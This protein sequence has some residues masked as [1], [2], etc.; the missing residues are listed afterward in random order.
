MDPQKLLR[1]Q[2][3][4]ADCE[5]M[6]PLGS[7]APPI[8][9]TSTF[10]FSTIKEATAAFESFGKDQ[11]IYTRIGNPTF[12][13][14]EKKLSAW[15]H[16]ESTCLFA[17]GMAAV[18]VTLFTFL[19]PGDHLICNKVVYGCTN[20]LFS[21]ILPA[22]G[23]Q[24]DFVDTTDMLNVK[25]TI[26]PNTKMVF[27]ETPANPTLDC[28]DIVALRALLDSEK[29]GALLVVD[30]T[31]ATP[32]NQ[33]PLELG[34]DLVVHSLTKYIN[35]HGDLI[36]GA[37]IGSEGHLEELKNIA[38]LVGATIAPDVAVLVDRGLETFPVRMAVHNSN[39]EKLA[40]FLEVH[41]LVKRVL[42]PGT[43]PIARAQMSGFG[44]MISFDFRDDVSVEATEKF[45]DHLVANSA[46]KLAVSLGDTKTLVQWPARMTHATVPE[47]ERL[48]KGISNT[49][50]RVSVGLEP[51]E[52]IEESFKKSLRYLPLVM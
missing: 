35:G 33:L 50:I 23:I 39:A 21:N 20:E 11:S 18:F 17:S 32:Y 8:F 52:Y 27:I 46:I 45:M 37:A 48:N 12:T 15:E 13:P 28:T 30:N 10:E 2:H 31:F 41:P 47:T 3:A 36:A 24:V 16:G 7:F 22:H 44:G 43:N 4:L 19:K 38:A 34:A 5:K 42:Y 29:S 40:Q 9:R 14:L 49:L 25:N 1:V 26:K 51:Y 6:H